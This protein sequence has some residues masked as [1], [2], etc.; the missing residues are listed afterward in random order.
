MP[1]QSSLRALISGGA[2]AALVGASILFTGSAANAGQIVVTQYDSATQTN[3]VVPA[4]VTSIDYRVVGGPGGDASGE[5]GGLGGDPIA[6]EGTLAVITGDTLNIWAGQA[7]GNG[8]GTGGASAPA[9]PASRAVATVRRQETRPVRAPAVAVRARLRSTAACPSLS[10]RAAVVAV[11]ADSTRACSP[12]ARA[13][14]AEMPVLPDRAAEAP[15]SSARPRPV[16]PPVDRAHSPART[17]PTSG[18]RSS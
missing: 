4:G 13:A 18:S 9:V 1:K 3:F 7:G 5:H 17:R 16:A 10:P 15:G 6:I 11:A 2:V 14:R 8:G 12:R